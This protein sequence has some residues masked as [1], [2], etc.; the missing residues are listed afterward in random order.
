MKF[1]SLI[2][3]IP[4]QICNL[5]QEKRCVLCHTPFHQ[6]Q[7]DLHYVLKYVDSNVSDT[8]AASNTS[9]FVEESPVKN[10]QEKFNESNENSEEQKTFLTQLI[11]LTT[12]HVQ[13]NLCPDCAKEINI[14][15]KGFCPL[16]GELFSD[17]NLSPTLC[18]NCAKEK[19]LWDSFLFLGTYKTCLRE[20]LLKAKFHNSI[21]SLSFLGKL[22]AHFWFMHIHSQALLTNNPI[23]YPAYIIPM[24]LHH[25]RI[26]ERGY[27]QCNEL[28]K[29]FIKEL[30]SL[31]S[32][33]EI[34]KPEIIVDYTSLMR[35]HFKQAQ[36][37]LSGKE[38]ILNVKNGF[39]SKN[40]QNKHLLLIDDIATTNSTLKE[41][42]R[43]LRNAGAVH[44]DILVLAKSS[45]F[46]HK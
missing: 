27:N 24:P 34:E 5:F 36:S 15:T 39:S 38:R 18:G 1:S 35:T 29:S 20:L 22:L 10:E 8:N 16:C 19:P 32:K 31:F 25:K 6:K 17:E 41:A 11:K 14:K 23:K 33:F 13:K 9:S 26:K 46:S 21:S 28:V 43:V 37:T 4:I 40:M 45:L 42:S 30:N 3:E 2:R 44:I 7:H 12:H